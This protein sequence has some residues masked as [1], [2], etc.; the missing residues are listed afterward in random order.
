MKRLFVMRLLG[1][2]VLTAF[3]AFGSASF[4]DDSIRT[5]CLK[6]NDSKYK[7]QIKGETKFIEVEKNEKEIYFIVPENLENSWRLLSQK[8]NLDELLGKK[9]AS[10]AKIKISNALKRNANYIKPKTSISTCL[11]EVPNGYLKS[12]FLFEDGKVTKIRIT[13]NFVKY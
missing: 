8:F 2:S 6:Q 7:C 4:T 3:N 11:H 9:D 5:D 10:I 1:L 13:Q 12:I